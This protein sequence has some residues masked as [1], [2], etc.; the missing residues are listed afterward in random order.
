MLGVGVN[1][2]LRT[3]NIKKMNNFQPLIAIFITLGY[4]AQRI[5]DNIAFKKLLFLQFAA[6]VDGLCGR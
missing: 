3:N 1:H 2:H 5:C 4:F 6:A